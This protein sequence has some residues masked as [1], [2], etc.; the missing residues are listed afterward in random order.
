[1]I[2]VTPGYI[3]ISPNEIIWPSLKI[4]WWQYVVRRHIVIGLI[5][6]LII[7]WAIPVGFV[8]LISNVNYL[9]HYTFL[10]WLDKIPHTIMGLITGLLPAVALGI[11]MSL[12][13]V[14]I[15]RESTLQ[16]IE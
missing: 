4:P 10:S 1:M 14:I 9:K 12:V 5:S 7:F 8:G 16:Y 3:G 6:A 15:R 13:P 2:V 11:L